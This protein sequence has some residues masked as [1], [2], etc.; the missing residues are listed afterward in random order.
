MRVA[1]VLPDEETAP[2]T[3]KARRAIEKQNEIASVA[4]GSIDKGGPRLAAATAT[5]AT[6]AKTFARLRTEDASTAASRSA[7]IVR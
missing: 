4:A 7:E 1:R 5:T 3:A 6:P 2:S